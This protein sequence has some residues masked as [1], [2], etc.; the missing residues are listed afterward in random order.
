MIKTFDSA[1]DTDRGI[2]LIVQDMTFDVE[3]SMM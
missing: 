1:K 3:E 2:F